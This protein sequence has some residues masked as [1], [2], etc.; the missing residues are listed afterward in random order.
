MS[1]SSF[2]S[3]SLQAAMKLLADGTFHSGE[4]LGAL[5]SVSR[6]AVWKTLKK[7]EPLG[8]E[9]TSV[10][11]KGYCINGGLD[12]LDSA[13]ISVNPDCGWAI[14]VF[15]QVDSTNAYLLRQPQPEKQVC[16]AE[17][18]AAGRGRR[19]RNWVSP[20][21]QNLYMSVAWGFDGG[22]ATLEGLSLAI[23]L[24]VVR[25]LR[26]F[27]V[28][29]VNLKW[30]NDIL[31][32]NKKLGGILIEVSGDPA[33]YCLAVV[34][35]GLNVSMDQKQADSIDQP[36]INLRDILKEQSLPAITR[37]QLAASLIDELGVILSDYHKGGFAAYKDEWLAAAAYLNKVV[38]IHAGNS[39]QEGV[40]CGLDQTGALLLEIEGKE[41]LYHGGE[42]SL[43][44]AYV[45]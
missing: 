21:A 14:N 12:L 43:R 41:V 40:F 26:Q 35:I 44:G 11:G 30:P 3:S 24:S 16:L 4:E 10:K 8:I 5:L 23:G 25:C 22:I 9:V 38:S 19:G 28:A 39:I 32:N 7:L 37:N 29:N 31:Y 36:W 27:G 18:Q 2:E 20:F 17:S 1:L 15:A 45:S 33:G 34:G 42:V 13:G 6:A